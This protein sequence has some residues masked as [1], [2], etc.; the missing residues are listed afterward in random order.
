MHGIAKKKKKNPD[1]NC[2]RWMIKMCQFRFINYNKCTILVED[3]DNGETMPMWGFSGG[4]VVKN[5]PTNV[6]DTGLTPG[7]GRLPEEGNGNLLQYSCLGNP[8]DRG[9]WQI[10]VHGVKRESD[11]VQLLSRV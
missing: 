10:T 4:S 11:I 9:T 7:S 2:E 8:M 5:P 3:V 6:G 1:V